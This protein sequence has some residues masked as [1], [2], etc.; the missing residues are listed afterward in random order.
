MQFMHL[1]AQ[2][3]ATGQSLTAEQQAQMVGGPES[4]FSADGVDFIIGIWKEG[5]WLMIPLAILALFIYFEATSVVLRLKRAKLKKT[6]KS[7][8]EG[9]L[10]QP[11]Q[12]RGHVGEV[13]R[14]VRGDSAHFSEENLIR[15]EAVRARVIPD[16]NAR[17]SVISTLV[18]LAPLMGLLGTVIGM[19]G[20][21]RGL[22]SASGQAAELVAEGIRVALITTQSGLMI[23]IPGYLFLSWVIRER[24]R[25][26]AFI[27]QLETA[28]VQ[29]VHRRDNSNAA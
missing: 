18:T 24:N 17:I 21:F 20:T 10:D 25:Y 11:D 3:A 27:S 13:I 19:L 1:L 26:L 6:P 5:G 28:V 7:V 9:W 23:A 16:V 22:S 12:A 29:R 4:L 2:A 15:V 8:W 14:F